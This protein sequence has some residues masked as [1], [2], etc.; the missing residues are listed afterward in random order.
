MRIIAGI[1][2]Y[3]ATMWALPQPAVAKTDATSC[4]AT[5]DRVGVELVRKLV[6]LEQRCLANRDRGKLLPTTRCV[7]IG[8]SIAE[9]SDATV[10][11]QAQALITRAYDRLSRRCT[12]LEVAL[13]P[14]DGVGFG[15]RC[16][17]VA[18][19]YCDIAIDGDAARMADCLI[20]THVASAHFMLT[21][22]HVREAPALCDTPRSVVVDLTSNESLAG[23][24]VT[25]GYPPSVGIPGSSADQTVEGHVT[26][27]PLGAL[28]LAVDRDLDGDLVDDNLLLSLIT[29]HAFGTGPFATVT[30]CQ[31][32]TPPP[33]I[34]DFS[35]SVRDAAAADDSM[36]IP[37][38]VSCTLRFAE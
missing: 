9:L 17:I 31:E 20:C 23:V 18:G 34:A 3:V 5:I 37:P 21:V 13:G 8:P 32:G 19:K 29:L 15:H 7:G 25:I 38:A 16:P 22:E 14:P 11:G 1:V 4:R 26:F 12:D 33:T 35:C 2:L 6:I 36:N 28:A 24:Q 30:F 27:V 10:H